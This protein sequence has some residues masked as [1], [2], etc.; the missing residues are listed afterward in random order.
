MVSQMAELRWGM[1]AHP[2][3]LAV[4]TPVAPPKR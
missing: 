1:G 3:L 4:G 2:L